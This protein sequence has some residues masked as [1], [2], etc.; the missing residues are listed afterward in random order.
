MELKSDTEAVKTQ[1]KRPRGLSIRQPWARAILSGEKDCENRS[2]TVA[3]APF[4]FV[5]H[6]GK[7]K[8]KNTDETLLKEAKTKPHLLEW[9]KTQLPDSGCLVAL[10]HV[11]SIRRM[12]SVDADKPYRSGPF[13]WTIDRV[14]PFEKPIPCVGRLQLWTIPDSVWKACCR[15]F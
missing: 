7:A 2:W 11:A 9:N 14:V 5:L 13:L 15:Q 6:I 1:A 3:D 12:T 4:W 10:V 8:T